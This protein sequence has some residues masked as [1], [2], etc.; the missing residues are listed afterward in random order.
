MR[1]P[2]KARLT[3]TK[4]KFCI[5]CPLGSAHRIKILVAL[6]TEVLTRNRAQMGLVNVDDAALKRF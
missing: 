6:S 3:M 5:E 2:V 4:R 1:R